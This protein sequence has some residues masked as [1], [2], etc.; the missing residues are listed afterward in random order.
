MK[1]IPP[2]FLSDAPDNNVSV[3][4]PADTA[5]R[6]FTSRHCIRIQFSQFLSKVTITFVIRVIQ[7]KFQL[8]FR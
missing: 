8:F 7:T 6:D 1:E 4:R 5:T 2:T 3:Y